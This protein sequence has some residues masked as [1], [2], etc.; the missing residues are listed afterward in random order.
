M[1]SP[2]PCLEEALLVKHTADLM[3]LPHS[4]VATAL[5]FL[6]RFHSAPPHTCIPRHVRLPFT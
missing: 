6:H 3:R 5:V 4:A 1:Q 2:F